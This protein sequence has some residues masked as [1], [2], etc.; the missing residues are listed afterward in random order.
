MCV[1]VVLRPL[2]LDMKARC[3]VGGEVC[4]RVLRRAA[5]RRSVIRGKR[6][7][8]SFA[9]SYLTTG[10][11]TRG[12]VQREENHVQLTKLCNLG[13]SHPHFYT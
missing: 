4:Y 12:P 6:G 2:S 3:S 13:K 1:E 9:T 10:N 11:R 7:S 8:L 5:D